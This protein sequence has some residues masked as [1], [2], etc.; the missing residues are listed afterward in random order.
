MQSACW[1]RPSACSGD[2][3]GLGDSQVLVSVELERH[4]VNKRDWIVDRHY[5][6]YLPRG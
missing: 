4:C 5:C 1:E 3:G 2:V 6:S